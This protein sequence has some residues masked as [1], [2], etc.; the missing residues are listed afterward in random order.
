[1]GMQSASQP[2]EG[3][4][5]LVSGSKV[6]GMQGNGDK[7]GAT[8]LYSGP[9]MAGAEQAVDAVSARWPTNGLDVPSV[10]Y[11]HLTLPTILLV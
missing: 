6:S 7:T 11:T 2:M 4:E 1:M 8:D 3:V 10:S 9:E 5:V